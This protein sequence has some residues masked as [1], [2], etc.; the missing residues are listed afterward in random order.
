MHGRL[1]GHAA[2]PESSVLVELCQP[3][4]RDLSGK[5]TDIQ[6]S[7]VHQALAGLSF[8]DPRPRVGV[9]KLPVGDN[10]APAVHKQPPV[11]KCGWKVTACTYTVFVD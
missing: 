3:V 1:G 6:L 9:D 2:Y 7:M 10:P 4:Y 11:N 8:G 5:G